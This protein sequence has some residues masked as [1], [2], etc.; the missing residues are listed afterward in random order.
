MKV[1]LIEDE[2]PAAERLAYLLNGYDPSIEVMGVLDSMAATR[3]WFQTRP[4]PDLIFLDIEL[5]DG[6][7]LAM[8]DELKSAC[9]FIFT[10]AYENFALEAFKW[11]S[12]DYLLKPITRQDLARSMKKFNAWSGPKTAVLEQ[13]GKKENSGPENVYRSRF[14]VKLGNRMLFVDSSSISY[15]FAEEKS[16]YLVTGEGQKY[17]LEVS[18]DKLETLLDPRQFF[19]MNRK[20]IG[21]AS[22]IREIRSYMTSRLRISLQAGTREDEAIVSRERV[23]AFRKWAEA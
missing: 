1:L 20:L 12:I 19:R 18:L 14:L 13:Q 23:P 4:E 8:L 2:P 6:N 11:M 22:S 3:E 17:P 15:F 7:S 9:P 16:V 5:A 10:T 21:S